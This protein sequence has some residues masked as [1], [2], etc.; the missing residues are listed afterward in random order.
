VVF[1]KYEYECEV[2]L[3]KWLSSHMVIEPASCPKCGNKDAQKVSWR[4]LHP[5]EKTHM[6]TT[7]KG[8]RGRL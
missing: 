5:H 1:Y 4:E 2:C 8:K 7:E 6:P 3:H